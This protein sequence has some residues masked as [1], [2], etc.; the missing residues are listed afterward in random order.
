MGGQFLFW[1]WNILPQKN[2][3]Y[4][5]K[6]HIMYKDSHIYFI[7]YWIMVINYKF[8]CTKAT[9]T[10]SQMIEESRSWNELETTPRLLIR[11]SRFPDF[12]WLSLYKIQWKYMRDKDNCVYKNWTFEF[13][14]IIKWQDVFLF[15]PKDLD[16]RWTDLVLLYSVACHKSWEG[17]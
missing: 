13:I 8:T 12:P 10:K 14:L 16:I 4:H 2:N 7:K 5:D 17:L 1:G 11:A 6:S 3:N 9:L 15:I